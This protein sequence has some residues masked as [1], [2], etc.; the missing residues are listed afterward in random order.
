MACSPHSLVARVLVSVIL[1]PE[2]ALPLER[3]QKDTVE[4]L[5]KVAVTQQA[6]RGNLLLPNRS[7]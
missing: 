2:F 5:D 7:C 1:P 6:R 3:K 4:I